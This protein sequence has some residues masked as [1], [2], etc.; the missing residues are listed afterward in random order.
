MVLA[1]KVEL[2]LKERIHKQLLDLASDDWHFKDLVDG[3][4]L[5]GV[6]SEQG[7]DQRLNLRRVVLGYG[8]DMTPNDLN[9][10]GMQILAVERRL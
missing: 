6:H 7:L 1:R 8:L 9:C 4:P 10:K 2:L 3:W 5:L